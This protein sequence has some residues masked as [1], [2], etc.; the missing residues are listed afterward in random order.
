M[1]RPITRKRRFARAIFILF[2]LAAAGSGAAWWWIFLRHPAGNGKPPGP[3]GPD[4]AVFVDARSLATVDARLEVYAPDEEAARLA[5]E[6]AFARGAEILARCAH[7]DPE[8]EL[9]KLS[10]A[11][12]GQPVPI[13]P[14]LAAVLAHAQATAELTDGLIDPTRGALAEIWRKCAAA[15]TRPDS[16]EVA[17]ATAAAGWS[18]IHVDPARN[19]V[20]LEKPGIQFEIT[21]IARGFA[22]DEMLGVLDKHGLPCALVTI[23]DTI[24][25]GRPP[26]D[27]AGWRVG[28]RTFGASV[29]DHITVSNCAVSTA[30]DLYRF[31]EMDGMRYSHLLDPATGLGLS[32]RIA[33]TVVA[34]TA[35][36]SNPFA[37]FSCIVPE[38]ALHVFAGGEISCRIVTI[39]DLTPVERA[40][41]NFPPIGIP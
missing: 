18:S 16:D 34:P 14:T 39:D 1:A 37:T 6:A 7:Q 22:A 4:L 31:V 30:G 27:Q 29:V 25:A 17:R 11:P 5:M 24:R 32:R 21:G 41:S 20:V 9:S 28:I 12:A 33:A 35:T 23:A 10:D 3:R 38:T 13:S 36:Q 2:V 40:T 15:G 26:P 8:S 19:I